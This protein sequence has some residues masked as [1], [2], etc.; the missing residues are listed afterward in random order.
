MI[1]E[2]TSADHFADV[3]LWDHNVG[4]SAYDEFILYVYAFPM[5]AGCVREK[6]TNVGQG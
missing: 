4:P 2:D 5:I 3:F 1:L 6:V